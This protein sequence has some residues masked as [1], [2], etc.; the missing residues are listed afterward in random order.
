[1]LTWFELLVMKV[2]RSDFSSTERGAMPHD[3]P[4]EPQCLELFGSID[5][6]Q[7]KRAEKVSMDGLY[8][9]LQHSFRR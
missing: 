6:C 5:R 4:V 2:W 8:H 1:M 9:G 3:A 7:R